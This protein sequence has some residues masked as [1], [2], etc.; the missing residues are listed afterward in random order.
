MA[1]NYGLDTPRQTRRSLRP[2]IDSEAFGRLSERFAR[3]L[4][5]ARFLVYMTIF[6]STWVIWNFTAPVGYRISDSRT[7][8]IA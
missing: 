5:T 3:F 2:H 6:V 8:I 7:C 1:R 4:G